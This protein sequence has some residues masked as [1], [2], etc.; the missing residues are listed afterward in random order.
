LNSGHPNTSKLSALLE[1][2]VPSGINT[3]WIASSLR[4]IPRSLKKLILTIAYVE[5]AAQ[6]S[7]W[8]HFANVTK[9]SPSF[10]KD[11]NLAY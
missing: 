7:Y 9:F 8:A 10:R 5:D 1:T 3:T 11:G 2:Q 4:L 6:S